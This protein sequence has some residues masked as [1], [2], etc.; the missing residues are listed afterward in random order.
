MPLIVT[1]S[2]RTR[3]PQ[4]R[5]PLAGRLARGLIGAWLPTP[6]GMIDC[7]PYANH[8]MVRVGDP[9]LLHG[10]KGGFGIDVTTSDAWRTSGSGTPAL[11]AA[12]SIAAWLKFPSTPALYSQI[13]TRDA[14][15]GSD[16]NLFS[17]GLERTAAWGYNGGY[18]HRAGY[19]ATTGQWNLWHLSVDGTTSAWWVDAVSQTE[20]FS[21]TPVTRTA[22]GVI[23]FNER[24]DNA[25]G[26]VSIGRVYLWGR[27][28]TE[29][30]VR[31]LYLREWAQFAPRE[32]RIW[33]PGAAPAVPN[34]T[35]VYAENILAAS[36][37]YRVTLDYA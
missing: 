27:A 13:V 32:R 20:N 37:D 12:F 28:I 2:T 17:N 6:G 36:A 18:I 19:V 5:V 11:G 7:S 26:T 34:I 1:R 10:V 33:V 16:W 23:R 35:A 24:S 31:E 14:G 3:Q 30:E 15:S 4:G 25:R 8:G 29:S 22:N 9:V 21:T